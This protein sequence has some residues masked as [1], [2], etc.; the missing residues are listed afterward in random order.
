M[1]QLYIYIHTY[2]L[3]AN[4]YNA[5]E[6]Y[7]F[8]KINIISIIRRHKISLLSQKMSI[9]YSR[10]INSYY[11]FQPS[12]FFFCAKLLTQTIKLNIKTKLEITQKVKLNLNTKLKRKKLT[13][14][15]MK[16]SMQIRRGCH[17]MVHRIRRLMHP[18][19]PTSAAYNHL[20][21]L[22]P[23]CFKNI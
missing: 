7:Q 10:N 9:N 18:I 20:N 15:I 6:R 19:S 3:V 22:G 17:V 1:F 4:P 14:H 16:T 11:S 8:L 13:V 2:R 12:L 23:F 5:Q 21:F